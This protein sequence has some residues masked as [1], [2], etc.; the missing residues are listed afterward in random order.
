MAVL[1]VGELARQSGVHS[2]TVRYYER[3][4]LLP[5]PVRKESGHRVYAV[6]T[7]RRLRFIKRAQALGFSL[8]E[9]KELLSFGADPDRPC[10]EVCTQVGQKL[11]EIR[12]KIAALRKIERTLKRMQESCNGRVPVRKCPILASL[13]AELVA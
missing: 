3:E 8:G 5:R 12:T 13:A 1:S 4:G 9:V 2:E 6:A 10:D 7:V 11:D